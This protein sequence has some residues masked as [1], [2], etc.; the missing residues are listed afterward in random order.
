[1][2]LKGT[3]PEARSAFAPFLAQLERAG[4]S[5]HTRR[6]YAEDLK[7][8]WGFFLEKYGHSNWKKWVESL[9]ASDYR[10]FLVASESKWARATVIRKCAALRAWLEFLGA[11][12]AAH[13]VPSPKLQRRLPRH[14]EW[15]DL[16]RVLGDEGLKSWERVAFE[17]MFG[18]GLRISEALHLE[19]QNI[20]AGFEFLRVLGKG[21]KWRELPIPT[22]TRAFLRDWIAIRPATDHSVLLCNEDGKRLSERSLRRTLE[23]ALRRQGLEKRISPHGLRHS[24]ASQ[25]LNAGADLKSLQKLLGHASLAATQ[26]YTHLELAAILDEHRMRHP[27]MRKKTSR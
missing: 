18:C 15:P 7:Q 19:I 24:F 23:H 22:K 3:H 8:W 2:D 17:L 16:E 11:H 25:L 13:W 27:L 26:R 10:A 12:S 14:L 5:P 20:D 21:K 9:S 4:Y 1:M 6:A